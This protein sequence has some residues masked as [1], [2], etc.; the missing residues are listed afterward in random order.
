MGTSLTPALVSVGSVGL[1]IV[2]SLVLVR[3]LGFQGLA[4]STAVAAL[5]NA[6]MLLALLHRRLDGLEGAKIA[7]SF[8]R[9]TIAA[10][11]MGATVW[12]A[13]QWLTARW[14]GAGLWMQ[15]LIVGSDIAVGL[16]VLG[17]A[18]RALGIAELNQAMTRVAGRLRR[19]T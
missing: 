13:D 8:A 18:A 14:P 19:R 11:M 7:D 16:V 5:S 9:I 4:L 15:M 10:A 1:N 6:A 2:L 12:L 3:V 17:A